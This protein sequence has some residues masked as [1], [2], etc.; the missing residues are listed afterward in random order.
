MGAVTGKGLSDLIREEYGIRITFVMMV[1][2]LLTNFGNVVGEFAGIAGGLELFGVSKYYLRADW[3][4]PCLANRGQRPIQE[5][6]EGIRGCLL[7]L[8][9]LPA[10][11]FPGAS[12][13]GP[14]CR[15]RHDETSDI[16]L[17]AV[18]VPMVG[19][20]VGTTIAPWMQFYL[21]ASIVEKGVTKRV[22]NLAP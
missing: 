15:R 16:G 18:T 7:L 8:H 3:R 2:I 19:G 22:P 21:Q 20:L 1:G 14:R 6:G 9:H 17:W 11:R 4:R 5:R 12:R 13:L 10:C